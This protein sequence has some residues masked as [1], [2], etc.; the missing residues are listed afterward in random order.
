MPSELGEPYRFN[1]PLPLPLALALAV[2]QLILSLT[3]SELIS[4]HNLGHKTITVAAT[5]ELTLTSN[6]LA[7]APTNASAVFIND[8][9]VIV[10]TKK[11]H[12]KQI[13][14]NA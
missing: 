6:N 14:L 4:E 9:I 11:H 2:A 13:T 8:T 1:W 5:N 10:T 3:Q 7:I 12:R